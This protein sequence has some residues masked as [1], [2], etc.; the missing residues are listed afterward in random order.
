[1]KWI[2][3]LVLVLVVGGVFLAGWFASGRD[4]LSFRDGMTSD[5]RQAGAVALDEQDPN[6][7]DAALDKAFKAVKTDADRAAYR[8][9]EI[10]GEETGKAFNELQS[11]K[12]SIT[13]GQQGLADLQLKQAELYSRIR[14]ACVAELDKHF[15]PASGQRVVATA[16]ELGGAVCQS[17]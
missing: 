10:Y 2:L 14:R 12:F 17:H 4:F 8:K 6:R 1:M 16:E 13:Q 11:A 5:F 3:A 15:P 9:L 7:L